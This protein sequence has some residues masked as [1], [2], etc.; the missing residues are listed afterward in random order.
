MKK[1]GNK[2]FASGTI[3]LTRK[4][5]AKKLV[6]VANFGIVVWTH[7]LCKRFQ[8]APTSFRFPGVSPEISVSSGTGHLRFS[9][10][11]L[12]LREAKSALSG[13][14]I[15]VPNKIYSVLLSVTFEWESL[16]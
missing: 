3:L 5:L 13:G 7:H 10:D 14:C 16:V 4:D 6:S 11:K 9:R 8:Q 2:R 15:E 1:I 12:V